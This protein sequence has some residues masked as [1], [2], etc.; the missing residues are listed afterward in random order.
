[1]DQDEGEQDGADDFDDDDEST[2]LRD[3]RKL[4]ELQQ[5]LGHPQKAIEST[6][7]NILK[8]EQKQDKD[9]QK[10]CKGVQDNLTTAQARLAKHIAAK[11]KRIEE[12]ENNL[13]QIHKKKL[14]ALA[15][16]EEQWKV[17]KANVE[18][19]AEQ[20]AA[21]STKAIQMIQDNLDTYV[22]E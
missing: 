19:Q 4:L 2:D 12:H 18:S 3:N 10:A 17:D 22:A 1:M 16:L 20:D 9:A 8:L 21:K 5:K 7:A 14:A 11:K 15:H 13:Q 6:K